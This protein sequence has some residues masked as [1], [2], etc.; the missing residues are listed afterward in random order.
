MRNVIGMV[1]SLLVLLPSLAAAAQ[2]S[3]NCTTLIRF[4]E[5]SFP[6]FDKQR[7][8]PAT[9][10][11]GIDADQLGDGNLSLHLYGW[12]RVDLGDR[13]TTEA[14]TTDG[15]LTYGYLSYRF[16]KANGLLK[17]GRF[18]VF[19]GGTAE[20][21]DG[22]SAQADI[23]PVLRGL[24]VSLF[25][26]IPTKLD[27]GF[28]NRGDYIAGGRVGFR[29][30]KILDVGATFV[31]E[32]GMDINGPTAD[33]KTYR[34]LVGGDIWLSPLP[35]LELNGRSTYNTATD[36]VAEHAYTLTIAP[37][38]SFRITG[39]FNRNNLKDYFSATNL[40]N[41]FSPDLE[42]KFTN[43]GGDI[44]LAPIKQVEL[45]ADYRHY[46][47][48]SKG[49]SNRY[50]GELR[51]SLAEDIVR[52]GFSYHRL[53]A[54]DD[55][56]SFHEVRGYAMF[57]PASLIASVDA[58]ADLYDHDIYGQKNV[59]VVAVSLG[60]K[61]TPSLTV[62]GDVSYGDNPQ[63]KQDLRGVLRLAFNFAGNE[64]GQKK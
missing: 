41:L 55:I 30:A 51:L 45:T 49:S 64:K 33:P 44:T 28:D 52:S 27:R 56:N 4:E 57:T 15:D 3:A 26:G 25:A 46:R 60:Y 43:Y 32:G 21:I 36:A 8:V 62:S 20:Q 59:Y 13:S 11:L 23:L 16:E 61:V 12:G 22:V 40:R 18:F 53:D 63:F 29:V 7:V 2:I 5:R 14:D 54:A 31:R 34:Q 35:Q 1:V 39:V 17:G 6:G 48:D 47:R 42:D 9:Q 50:G 58:I 37:L 24:T 19:E 38:S 10:F